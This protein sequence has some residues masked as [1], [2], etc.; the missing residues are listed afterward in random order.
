VVGFYPHSP[1]SKEGYPVRGGVVL[2]YETTCK[3]TIKKILS[4]LLF[5][6]KAKELLWF[7][8]F[9]FSDN[10]HLICI[11]SNLDE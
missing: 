3:V 6:K 1:P 7:Y 4:L 2:Q 8:L 11:Q 10:I 9:R 5:S